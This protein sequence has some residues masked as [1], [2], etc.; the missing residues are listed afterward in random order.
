MITKET[1]EEKI[2]EDILA[3][4]FLHF[5]GN[6]L[7]V[8]FGDNR[9]MSLELKNEQEKQVIETL[10]ADPNLWAQ[11]FGSISAALKRSM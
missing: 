9:N 11:F 2:D 5:E 6:N 4:V 8:Q 10:L 1:K 3:D 7:I